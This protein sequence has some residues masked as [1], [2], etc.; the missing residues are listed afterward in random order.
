M[1]ETILTEIT[2]GEPKR[3]TRGRQ[4]LHSSAWSELIERYE[5]SGMTQ[6]QFARHEGVKYHTF[7]AQLGRHR[8][9]GRKAQPGPRFLEARLP[10]AP[11]I[12][13]EVTLVCGM[14]VRGDEVESLARLIRLLES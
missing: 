4:I 3:D 14:V 9:A 10:T 8:R 2:D 11:A 7:V 13:L 12:R 1:S 6:V 5:S